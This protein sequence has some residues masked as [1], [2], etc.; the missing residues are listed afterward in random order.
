M[1]IFF[2]VVLIIYFSVSW[3]V[4]SRGTLALAG[5]GFQKAF[6][7]AFW[8]MASTFI[9]GQI[10]E[11]G[12]PNAFA[13]AVTLT[14]SLWLAF[15]LYALLFVVVVDFFRLLHHFFH[16]FPQSL[17]TG[18]L[19]GKMLFVYGVTIALV[20]ATGGYFNAQHPRV[21]EVNIEIPKKG[22]QRDSLRIVLATDVHLGVIWQKDRAQKLLHDINAQKP[23][24]VIFVGD[25]VDH[26]PVPVVENDIG[27]C[28]EKIEAPLGVFAT[29]G[30]HEFIGEAD[31][32]I[33]YFTGHGVT[34]IRDSIY[35]IDNI[36][37]LAGREDREKV[38]FTGIK[39]KTIDELLTAKTIDLP[40]LLLDHQPVE[41][42]KVAAHGIDLMVS[43]HT[44][45]GQLWPLGFLTRLVYEN[46]FGLIKKGNTH[47]YTSSGYGSWGPPVRT[48]NRPELVVFNITFK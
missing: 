9:I 43:G 24:L 26:N 36:V 38:N 30:N 12:S 39:R 3:Y 16:V 6:K 33:D 46:D 31:I 13:R 18:V 15:F 7:W 48:G 47:F 20:V 40:L 27:K 35:T 11:R 1:I 22:A 34:Y 19:S 5:S 10:L 21:R 45:K 37:Q 25:L 17:T 8:L 29:T 28:F 14:G 44:H 23:D 41:Y 42:D 32:S 2:S 4:Y